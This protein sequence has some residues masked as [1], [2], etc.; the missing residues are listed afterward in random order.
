MDIAFLKIYVISSKCFSIENGYIIQKIKI[1]KLSVK[2]MKSSF[3]LNHLQVC[4]F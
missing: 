1:L 4:F 3:A 2:Y